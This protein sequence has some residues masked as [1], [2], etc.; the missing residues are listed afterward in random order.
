[1][2]HLPFLVLLPIVGCLDYSSFLQQ[3]GE[4]YC[5][6]MAICNP[7]QPCVVPDPVDT[8]YTAATGACEFDRKLARDC[9]KGTWTCNTEFV[10]F[11]YPVGPAACNAVCGTAFTE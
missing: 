9:L 3:R 11:E 6:E 4:R 8:G 7:D 1:M 10:G 2:R 5:E